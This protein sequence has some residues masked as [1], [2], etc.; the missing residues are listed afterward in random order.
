[1]SVLVFVLRSIRDPTF[2][3]FG[4]KDMKSAIKNWLV[5]ATVAALAACGGGDGSEYVYSD[6]DWEEVVLNVEDWTPKVEVR[7]ENGAS[8]TYPLFPFAQHYRASLKSYVD[9]V[10]TS[11]TSTYTVSGRMTLGSINNGTY[12][13]VALQEKEYMQPDLFAGYSVTPVRVRTIKSN[14]TLNGNALQDETSESYSFYDTTFGFK[15]GSVSADV[16][17]RINF[18][19]SRSGLPNTLATNDHVDLLVYDVFDSFGRKLG[20]EVE[21]VRMLSVRQVAQGEYVAT[22]DF[23]TR[24]ENVIGL[25]L[26]VSTTTREMSYS[27]SKGARSRTTS[28]VV[29]DVYGSST[30]RLTYQLVK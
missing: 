11:R 6:D 15:I 17:K 5:A 23:I 12:N 24:S 18:D 20:K 26:G 21:S 2:D 27:L 22:A 19:E 14:Q 7:Q 9:K 30:S 4:L 10:G 13:G 8:V 16:L 25:L 3:I 1:M 28:M 29:D